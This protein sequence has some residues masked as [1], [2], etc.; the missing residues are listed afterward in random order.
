MSTQPERLPVRPRIQP[1]QAL[2]SY[3]EH[4]ADANH[5]PAAE[6]TR[7]L[8]SAT[9]TTRY[10]MLAPTPATL[11]ALAE[12]GGQP[13]D[14][15]REATLATYDGSSVDLTGLDPNLQSSYRQIAARGW[16]PG[17]GT[18]IC[19][20][21]L[22]EHGRWQTSWRVP[23]STVCLTHGTYLIGTCPGCQRPFRSARGTPLRPIGTLTECGNPEGRRGRYCRTDLTALTTIPADAE[24]VE[25][26]RLDSVGRDL[27]PVLG[28]PTH[29]AEYSAARRS[30]A[31]LL[32]HIA[33]AATDSG[34]LPAW[35]GDLRRD[36]SE[37]VHRWGIRPPTE[38]PTRSRALTSAHAVLV[39]PNIDTAA[40]LFGPWMDAI[41]RTSEGVL[42]WAADHHLPHPAT[43]RLVMATHAPRRRLSRVL[44]DS[45]RLVPALE[46]VPQMIP[47]ALYEEHLATF[48]TTRS[49][50]GRNFA[51]LCIARTDPSV[52]TWTQ[53]GAVLGLPPD[54]TMRTV[55]SATT[56]LTASPMEVLDALHAM[57]AA[58]RPRN[59][60]GREGAVRSLVSRHSWFRNWARTRRPGTRLN[61]KTYAV[62]W[63]WTNWAGAHLDTSPTWKTPPNAKERA[64]YQRFAVSLDADQIRD[65]ILLSLI[66]ERA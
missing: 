12:I 11:T 64:Q 38:I 4:L 15:L 65:L 32:L 3:L 60:R 9:D 2:D 49:D 36:S 43:T 20:V 28:E 55:R 13:P 47:L 66:G 27:V 10:L 1:G 44:D 37:G 18:S 16:A 21:C 39:C 63:L 5:L 46:N 30:L 59:W 26:Q 48:L 35:V 42:G 23:T 51:A 33:S 24:C 31:V 25:R 62:T 52:A 34:P 17:V 61:S 41:P 6:I 45:P 50:V 29:L 19:P 7:R 56:S 58:S 14:R 22:A 8:R 53:A 57:S 54:L 40:A